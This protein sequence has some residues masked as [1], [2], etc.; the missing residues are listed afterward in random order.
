MKPP[1]RDYQNQIVEYAVKNPYCIIA[2]DPG[3]GKTRCAIEIAEKLGGNTL[4]VCPSYL[5]QNWIEE[6]RLWA[7]PNKMITAIQKG[8]QIYDL[9]DSDYAI[10]SYDLCQK[11][12]YFFEWADYL[13]LDESQNIKSMKAKRTTFMHRVVYENSI[14]RVHMLTGTPIKN[15]VAELYS[16]LALANY[17][18][19]VPDG[20]F[21]D[22]YPDEITF[23]D[24]F[25][26]R[27]EYVIEINNRFVTIVKWTGLRNVDELKGWLKGLYLRIKSEDVLDLPPI[28]YK[29]LI[30]STL[31]DHALRRAFDT[32]FQ[33]EGAGDVNPTAKA[34]AA[35]KKAPITVKY[36]RDLLEEVDCLLIYTDHVA[37]SEEIAKA[38]NTVALNGTVSSARRM[39]FAKAFQ[40]GEGRVLVATIGALSTGINLTRAHHLILNDPCW[41]PGDLKQTIYRIQRMTQKNTCFV[42]RM[43]GSPQDGYIYKVLEDKMATIE[44]AT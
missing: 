28:V 30:I 2:A 22:R 5:I 31:P 4:V 13:V 39:Q 11:A 34:E 12:E 6:I 33:V 37:A 25:S 17:N 9:V 41:T 24:H 7:P 21:L 19:S 23:A 42:H 15:R 32:H 16:L 1:L 35:L 18:P 3:L 40:E 38:F 44:K 26:Y 43:V 36:A 20:R 10:I 8:S 14:K 29:D 27:D